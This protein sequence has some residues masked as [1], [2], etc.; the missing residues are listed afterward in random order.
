MPD[1][2]EELFADLRA[3]TLPTVMPPGTGPLRRAARRRRAA[4]SAAA[5]VAVLAVSGLVAVI[6][7][8]DTATP[9]A[10][11][12]ISA[13]PVTEDSEDV[14]TALGIDPDSPDPG[15]L[16]VFDPGDGLIS[17]TR[18]LLGGRYD[19]KMVCFGA[20]TID[21]TVGS[22]E[23]SVGCDTGQST[24]L[25]VP[26]TVAK[27]GATVPITIRPHVAGRGK[28]FFGYLP[29][30]SVAD[31]TPYLQAAEAML[32][33][34]DQQRSVAAENFFLDHHN[35]SVDWATEAGRYRIR[36]ACA[37][38]GSATL[39]VARMNDG[40]TFGPKS[41]PVRC[42]TTKSLTYDLTSGGLSIELSP[43]T[44]ALG[45]SAGAILV[46]KA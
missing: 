26:F 9:A 34:F 4:L 15:A 33:E 21:V 19:M 8:G 44:E 23:A 42:G 45:R 38:H 41:V 36:A 30:L 31:R 14:A 39:T 2:I 37:G 24:V 18:D 17:T 43:D 27:P 40:V 25:T 7:P 28:A 12:A 32:P 5:A 3:E 29:V 6:R 11:P 20:G 35:K 16:A 22:T 10:A 13:A 1:R 46:E